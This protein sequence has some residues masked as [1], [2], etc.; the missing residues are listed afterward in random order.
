MR[1][2]TIQ[3]FLVSSLLNLLGNQS[4]VIAASPKAF[5]P[6]YQHAT[7]A[8]IT[9][10]VV[11]ADG[12][13]IAN[14]KVTVKGSDNTATTDANGKFSI[15]ATNKDI[16]VF[17]MQ[18]FKTQE[19]NVSP[20]VKIVLQEQAALG[21]LTRQTVGS[22]DQT[23]KEGESPVAVDIIPIQEVINQTGHLELNQILHYAA[24]SFN[25]NRQTGADA[26][27]HVDPSSLRGLGPDQILFLVNGKRYHPSALINVFG[28]RGRG[29]AGT[30][31]NSIPA[32]AVERIEI[33]RDGAAAQ[34][35]SDA[36][37][38]VI[39]VV[40][41]TGE[42]GFSGSLNAGTHLTGWGSSLNYN[43]FGK[44]LPQ[45]TD[46]TN[47]N[48]SLNYNFL[49]GKSSFGIT[50]DYLSKAKMMRPNNEKAFPDEN[51]RQGASNASLSNTS[52]FVNGKIPVQNGEIYLFGGYST[53]KTDMFLWT[54]PASDLTRTVPQIYTG[55]YYPHLLSDISNYTASVGYKAQLGQ[56]NLDVSNTLGQ[57]RVQLSTSNTLNPSLLAKSPTSFDNGGFSIRQNTLNLDL[58]RKFGDILG[59]LN[60]AFGGEYRHELYTIFAGEE[61]S[62]KTY[63]NPPFVVTNPD[64]TKDTLTKGGSSQGF[65]GFRP[66]QAL[67]ATRSVF[68]VYGDAELTIA[69][70]FLLTGAGRFENYSDFGSAFGGKLAALWK[71]STQ[72][73]MRGSV[74]TGF[75]APSL[76]QVYFR[77]TINDVDANG[78]NFE[79]ILFNNRSELTQKLGIPSL[80][81]EK[82]VN[83][84]IGFVYRPQKNLS[85]SIDAYQIQ[86]R[87]RIVLTGSFFDDD[88]VLGAELKR[89]EVKAAQ[90]YTNALD[91]KT[92]G[93]DLAA[94]YNTP[95][96]KGTLSLTFGANFNHMELS[97]VRTA[98]TLTA[99]KDKYISPRELQF[100]LSSAPKNKF[101]LALNYSLDKWNFSIRNTYFS[102]VEIIG[103]NGVLGY[104]PTLDAL[105]NSNEAAWRD[106]VT[107]RYQ[108]R[109][110]TDV[111]VNYK[112]S[113]SFMLAIGGN[114]VFDVYPSIQNSG[115]TDGGTHWDGVQMGMGGA[116]FFTKVGFKF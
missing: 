34:Y 32:A 27:D 77:S 63:P 53:R 9:G 110:V 92:Q 40:L 104:D 76:A 14:V 113:K 112:F 44:I 57:N 71:V 66:E 7:T 72:F 67:S 51:Y 93:I 16:L 61:A 43:N 23:R 52:L 86:V 18:G 108:P 3:V 10:I 98:P 12:E 78:N 37:A 4:Y 103:T 15:E 47:L 88:D 13:P 80:T 11:A 62:W 99:K 91:T 96:S 111:M 85:I 20:F 116:Y 69:E 22:R 115:S 109:L 42:Q 100:I 55:D 68:G 73:S 26:A 28:T 5:S 39:N 41:K 79:K 59:G 89:L 19:V 87:D 95:L 106:K 81:A 2:L 107:D 17:S 70:N 1:K 101:N 64:G 74:Q 8:K 21:E 65:P 33:L 94:T 35:G 75:R 56:W 105:R 82:S 97:D 60:V 58:D 36:V 83:I 114:N 50:A 46:G 54:I 38:G 29:N 102:L 30:D 6:M 45:T 31:L 84:G 25:A 49:V 90:F 24:P 48:G